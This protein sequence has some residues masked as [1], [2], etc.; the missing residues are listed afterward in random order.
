MKGE[1]FMWT[2]SELKQRGKL[3]FKAN[4]WKCVLVSLI[5]VILTGASSGGSAAGN[6]KFN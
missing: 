5:L 1:K 6:R 4:Y 2:R 3:A